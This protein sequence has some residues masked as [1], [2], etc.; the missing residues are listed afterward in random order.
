M[1]WVIAKTCSY[2]FDMKSRVCQPAMVLVEH[3]NIL[4]R[5][6]SFK[7]PPSHVLDQE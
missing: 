5:D 3:S 4:Y 6:S 7:L 1:G 2:N